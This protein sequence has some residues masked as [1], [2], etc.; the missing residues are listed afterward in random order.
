MTP[1]FNKGD[2]TSG[3]LAGVHALA[4]MVIQG[5]QG[6]VPSLGIVAKLMTIPWIQSVQKWQALS[7]RW[8][9]L[10]LTF[11]LLSMVGSLVIRRW[12]GALLLGGLVLLPGGFLPI[13]LLLLPL[14]IGYFLRSSRRSIGNF[15]YTDRIPAESYSRAQRGI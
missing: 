8:G 6:I 15:D 3:I 9:L 2:D 5:P 13:L 1:A 10:T 7:P 14:V 11:G 4:D 12:R